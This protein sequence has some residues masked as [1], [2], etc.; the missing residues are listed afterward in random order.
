MN[1]E[2]VLP[3]IFEHV[4]RMSYNL[5]TCASNEFRNMLFIGYVF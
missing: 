3:M 1:F 4:R 5:Q 2:H